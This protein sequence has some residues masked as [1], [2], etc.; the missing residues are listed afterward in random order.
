M[1]LTPKK[2]DYTPAEMFFKRKL[3]TDIP[4]IYTQ[5]DIEKQEYNKQKA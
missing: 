3:K 2:P 5:P 1:N 4:E